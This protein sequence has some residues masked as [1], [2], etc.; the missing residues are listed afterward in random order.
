MAE[1]AA[2]RESILV[3]NNQ[4]AP[5]CKVEAFWFYDSATGLLHHKALDDEAGSGAGLHGVHAGGQGG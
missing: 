2:R 5:T 3:S 4:K 1:P